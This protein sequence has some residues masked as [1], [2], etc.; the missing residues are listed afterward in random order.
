MTSFA[1]AHAGTLGLLIFFVFFMAMTAWI[2]RPG[3]K[4][5]YE[6]DAQIPLKDERP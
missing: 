6:R 1:S 4:K 5:K 3:A 2:F